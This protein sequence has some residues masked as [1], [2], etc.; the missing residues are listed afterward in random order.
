MILPEHELRERMESPLNLLNRLRNITNPHKKSPIP[1]LPPSSEEII[2]DL[3][4][5]ITT[6]SIKSKALGI[7]S[8]AM[9]E[10]KNKLPEVQ[11]PEKLAAIAAEM[12][13][14]LNSTDSKRDDTKP[15]A[16]IIIY[17]PQV[18]LEETFNMV[19]LVE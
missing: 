15:Q 13:K 14:V 16:Q 4:D 8:S 5:K 3:E 7:M 10:L 11:K 1:Q 2:E 17:A 9:D 18:V 6:G 12:N 19:E